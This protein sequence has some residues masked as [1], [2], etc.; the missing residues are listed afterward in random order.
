[1]AA[2]ASIR[3][4]S[5]I[6]TA[7]STVSTTAVYGTFDIAN[8]NQDKGAYFAEWQSGIAYNEHATATFGLICSDGQNYGQLYFHGADA[9]RTYDG[10]TTVGKTLSFESFTAYKSGVS[11]GSSTMNI[12]VDGTAGTSGVYDGAYGVGQGAIMMGRNEYGVTKIRDL[13]RY[14]LSYAAGLAKLEEITA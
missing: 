12:V 14:N 3:G 1:M 13:R 6:I 2:I 11:Y 10:T 8:H 5:P 9:V 4:S 7:A